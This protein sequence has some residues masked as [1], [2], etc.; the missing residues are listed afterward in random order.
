MFI[1]E[2]SKPKEK[3][4]AWYLFT[5]AFI[6]GTQ[7]LTN[8]EIGIYIRLLCWNWNKRCSGI[9]NNENTYYRIGNC[10][11][12]SEKQSCLNILE[13]FFVLIGS[14]YQNEKQLQEYLYITHRIE[15]SKE[16]GKRGGRPKKP[17]DKPKHNLEHNLNHNLNETP[18]PIPIPIPKLNKLSYS[19]Y[20]LKFWESI[21]NKV[22]KGIAEKN[23]LKIEK[24][25]I[26]QPE[27]LADM[28]KNYYN[29]IEDKQ[30]AKQPAFWLS[31]KKYLDEQPKKK[32]NSPADPYVMRLKM[33]K[34]A[35]DA[36]KGS[37]FIQGY[38]QR[39]PSDVQRAISEGQ[40]T[41]EEAKQYLDFRG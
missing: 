23:Y 13:Q 27:K 15:T 37:S 4:N 29:S 21:P 40:F 30:F 39:Y 41:K 3:L 2:N 24:E 16:N 38:A 5:D 34:E 36:K 28:Y 19:S 32:D 22:S 9:L 7:H 6:A 25:W 1:E 14:H 20:F 31:A 18:I 8:E 35:V 10:I 26:E 17:S 11:T 33:F 12:D